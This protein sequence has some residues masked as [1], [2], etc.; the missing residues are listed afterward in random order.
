MADFSPESL[1]G[2]DNCIKKR[3][4]EE[5]MK[6]GAELFTLRNE[7]NVDRK[8]LHYFVY[9][10]D[11][12]SAAIILNAKTSAE[13]KDLIPKMQNMAKKSKISTEGLDTFCATK[14]NY[15]KKTLDGDEHFVKSIRELKIE[16]MPIDLTEG[17]S[18]IIS[19]LM[20]FIDHVLKKTGR[21]PSE[22]KDLEKFDKKMFDKMNSGQKSYSFSVSYLKNKIIIYSFGEELLV[23]NLIGTNLQ[24]GFSEWKC[25]MP[26]K[27][28]AELKNRKDYEDFFNF[29]GLDCR[30]E[31]V[32]TPMG[33]ASLLN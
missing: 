4:I 30:F 12:V 32:F 5:C 14:I 33:I 19:K 13:T 18:F 7:C 28:Q 26:N 21:V 16:K 1:T 6:S 25:Y 20:P 17:R 2:Y 3:N 22:I 24:D 27:T 29:G 15:I 23:L 8:I 9:M 10:L 31:K 11:E